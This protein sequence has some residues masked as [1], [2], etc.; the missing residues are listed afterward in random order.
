MQLVRYT[1][2]TAVVAAFDGSR[3]RAR[4]EPDGDLVRLDQFQ[5]A[6]QR[7]PGRQLH[8][9]QAR[10]AQASRADVIQTP[11]PGKAHLIARLRSAN[12]AGKPVVLCAHADTVGVERELWSVDPFAGVISGD[13]LYGRGSFDDK[14]GIAVFAAAAMR[15]ARARVPIHARHRAG[16]RGRRGGR[17]LRDR[18]ARREPL[19]QQLDAAYSLDE[20]GI[21]S[22][23]G[24]RPNLAAVTVRDKISLL[25]RAPDARRLEPLLPPAAAERDRPAR[26]RAGPDQPALQQAEALATRPHLPAR[27]GE[28]EQGQAGRG[29]APAG[30]RPPH[31]QDQRDL[32][33]RDLRRSDFGPLLSA[34][35]RGSRTPKVECRGIRSNV[36]P[37][38]AKATVNMR[39]LPGVTGEQAVRELRRTIHDRPVK[40]IVGSDDP[41]LQ[42]HYQ[43]IR[44]RQ[45]I[46]ASS[47]DTDL[48]R[49]AGARDQDAV[50]GHR[51]HAR[52]LRGRHGRR[53]VASARHARL[54]A[55]GLP[56][57]GRRPG[58]HCTES[59][60]ES[61]S[62][63]STRAPTWSSG[64]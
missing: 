1:L 37:G 4:R 63:V 32:Q 12:P 24:G 59:T 44:E 64:S 3:D 46:A 62:P 6:W 34:L 47:I 15:L 60:S 51:R 23:Q 43:S 31:P 56:R 26:S 41:N 50:P 36:I 5:H 19:L 48:Y 22:T 16:L 13:F 52:P 18:L 53:A 42:K 28:R 29:P 35:T 7:G 40:Y 49:Y 27:V 14:G 30:P 25:G 55:A 17:R 11:T 61:R 20:G 21:I 45:R 39:L 58:R 38:I 57:L 54:R 10:A 8:A 2:M 33:A 9:R